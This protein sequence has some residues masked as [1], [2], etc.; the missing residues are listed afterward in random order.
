MGDSLVLYRTLM[1]LLCQ[2][3]RLGKGPHLG[4]LKTLAWCIVGLLLVGKVSLPQWASQIVSNARQ[5]A[6]RERRLYRWLSNPKVV[7]VRLYGPLIREA[8]RR[9]G[10]QRLYLAL[11]TTTLW[12]RFTVIYLSVIYRGRAIPL[13]WRVIRSQSTSVSFQVYQPVLLRAAKLLPVGAKI[14]LLGD[15]G[16][17]DIELM[18][19]ARNLGWSF[20]LRLKSNFWV[21]RGSRANKIGRLCPQRGEARF[22]HNVFITKR[23]FGPVHLALAWC[24]LDGKTDPWYVVSDEPTDLTTFDEYGL[25][26]DTE[27][28]FLDE[29]SANFQIEASELDHP[30]QLSRLALVLAITTLALTSWGTAA[31]ALQL[32]R[33][34]DGHWLRGLSY[35]RIGW[36]FVRRCLALRLPLPTW[37]HLDSAEDPEP[38]FPSLR[39]A[40]Q[41]GLKFRVC[42]NP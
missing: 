5:Q 7:P 19:Q 35:L 15:R 29:K 1:A 28:L 9:W 6:S 8:L 40:R 31:C 39:Q 22:Y 11:D 2:H 10:S 42:F 41:P 14:V 37:L 20:R 33:T 24:D 38:A 26:F 18:Q 21:Y 32:R 16:F 17:A 12:N 25:R 34:L 23:W 27:E 36:N 4:Q 3:L 30:M 13:A